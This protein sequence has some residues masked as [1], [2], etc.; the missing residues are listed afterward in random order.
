M[1]YINLNLSNPYK[2]FIVDSKNRI[3]RQILFDLLNN[4]KN[5]DGC[6]DLVIEKIDTDEGYEELR[7]EF[8]TLTTLLTENDITDE[9][10]NEV[11]DKVNEMLKNKII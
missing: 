7:N 2:K 9:E 8:N 10:V 5:I 11:K 1:N 3:K 4:F 6:L